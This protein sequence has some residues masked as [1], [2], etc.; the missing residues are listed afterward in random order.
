MENYLDQRDS[1]EKENDYDQNQTT[2]DK[3]REV[4][5][6]VKATIHPQYSVHFF[7]SLIDLGG[8]V[9]KLRG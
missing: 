1:H 7:V 2:N 3:P 6:R 8:L 9:L 5:K 4:L